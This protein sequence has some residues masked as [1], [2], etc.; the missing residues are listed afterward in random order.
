[1]GTSGKGDGRR[2]EKREALALEM[3]AS[4][5]RVA[6]RT[7]WSALRPPRGGSATFSQPASLGVQAIYPREMIEFEAD[8]N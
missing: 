7:I 6:R 3:G 2:R 4:H 1:M 8:D 5:R